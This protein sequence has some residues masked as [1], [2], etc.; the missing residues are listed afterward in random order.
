MRC[1]SKMHSYEIYLEISKS[2]RGVQIKI[3]PQAPINHLVI[4]V[5]QQS[6]GFVTKTFKF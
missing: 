6:L 5:P 1:V 3:L 2:K 4:L